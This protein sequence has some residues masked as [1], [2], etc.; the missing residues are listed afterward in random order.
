M[1][2]ST[3]SPSWTAKFDDS[4]PRMPAAL[5]FEGCYVAHVYPAGVR[6]SS[7]RNAN[8]LHQAESLAAK[9]NAHEEL[10]DLVRYF[11]SEGWRFNEPTEK[12][13]RARTVL[14]KV[15]S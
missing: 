7:N 2:T 11:H 8:A 1:T 4:E 10:V 12:L 13:E 9:L 15:Q 6:E 5:I 14:A 3:T